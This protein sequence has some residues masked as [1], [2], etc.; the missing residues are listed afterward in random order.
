MSSL[1]PETAPVSEWE[2]EV[3]EI[4]ADRLSRIPDLIE[5]LISGKIGVF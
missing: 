1:R 2:I 5:D 3:Q 4:V